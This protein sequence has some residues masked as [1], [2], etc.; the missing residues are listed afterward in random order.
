MVECAIYMQ[1]W[2]GLA[3]CARMGTAQDVATQGATV[4]AGRR[5]EGDDA[6]VGVRETWVG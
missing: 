2:P 5:T 4:Q 1:D 3:M 6:W